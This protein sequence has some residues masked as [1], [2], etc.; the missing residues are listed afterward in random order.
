MYFIITSA[1]NSYE[2]CTDHDKVIYSF[3]ELYDFYVEEL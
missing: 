2:N 3:K 1:S